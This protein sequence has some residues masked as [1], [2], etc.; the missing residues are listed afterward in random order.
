MTEGK[1]RL[2]EDAYEQAFITVVRAARSGRR[3]AAIFEELYASV[4][5]G[6]RLD[7]FVDNL[8]EYVDVTCVGVIDRMFD[9]ASDIQK[10]IAFKALWP[11]ISSIEPQ[12]TS[13]YLAHT[14]ES[15]VSDE[16]EAPELTD[17]LMLTEIVIL[18]MFGPPSERSLL[19]EFHE[20]KELVDRN[21]RKELF[22][23]E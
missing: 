14:L 8:Q 10:H 2:P 11:L 6:V 15:C 18:S 1:H 17:F 23:E 4:P 20:S 7:R 13:A 19:R 22:G 16:L 12:V 21:H 3:A 9:K 5:K